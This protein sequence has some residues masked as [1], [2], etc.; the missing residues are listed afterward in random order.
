MTAAAPAAPSPIRVFHSPRYFAD[1]GQHVMPMRKFALVR[2]AIERSGLPARVEAPEPVSDEDLLRVHTPEYLQAI[3][4]GEPRALA[5]SQKF[6]WSP[7]LAGAVRFTNGGCI[8]ATFAALEDGIAGNLASGFH[9]AHAAHGEGFCTFNGL[10]VALERAR[11]E[12]RIRRALVVDMDLHYGN[13]TASLLASRPWA[14][15]LSIYGNWYKQNLAYRDVESE[16]APDTDNSWS[17]PVPNGS[18][19]AEYQG[20]LE[21]RLGPAIDRAE[22]DVILYQAGADPYREDPYSPLDLTHDDLRARDDLVFR[23]ALARGIPI[24]W[25]LAGGYTPDVS[26]VVEVHL[27]TFVAAVRAREA[28]AEGQ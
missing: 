8:A 7:E 5:E 16:R 3:V 21:R 14:F 9:H 24:A 1:I 22:P 27:N 28:R 15:G 4:T 11:A 26:R 23:T 18:G 13:G 19:G 25:V 6:P 2:E 17:V 10:V 12:G 20:I